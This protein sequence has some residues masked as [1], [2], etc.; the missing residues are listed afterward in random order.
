MSTNCGWIFTT[1]TTY[2]KKNP[3]CA[4]TFDHV[5]NTTIFF[6]P[7]VQ[8]LQHAVPPHGLWQQ[9]IYTIPIC[10]AQGFCFIWNMLLPYFLKLPCILIMKKYMNLQIFITDRQLH[11]SWA[12]NAY[13]VVRQMVNTPSSANIP[14]FIHWTWT[15]DFILF[16]SH[17]SYFKYSLEKSGTVTVTIII[18]IVRSTNWD[19]NLAHSKYSAEYNEKHWMVGWWWERPKIYWSGQSL[20]LV[21]G[22]QKLEGP[23]TGQ[24]EN[25]NH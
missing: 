12:L 4:V 20:F 23:G 5:S 2:T 18:T 21:S 22:Y 9:T 13:T 25:S 6:K 7:T 1:A 10:G 19:S 15:Y 14:P 24:R 3:L 11:L 16:L 8:R 17:S